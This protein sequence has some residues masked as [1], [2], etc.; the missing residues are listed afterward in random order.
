MVELIAVLLLVGVLAAVALPRLDQATGLHGAAWRDQIRAAVQH[1]GAL[2]HAQRR[3]VC[4]VVVTGELRLSIASTNPATSC[5]IAIPGPDGDARWAVD[6]RQLAI[7][8][9][10]GSTLYFQPDGRVT[11]NFSGSGSAFFTITVAGAPDLI[12]SGAT[13]Y[14]Q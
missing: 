7:T 3:V 6:P 11:Q 12:V 4:L 1:A 9:S 13:N 2:A 14:V 8:G 10:P 5:S